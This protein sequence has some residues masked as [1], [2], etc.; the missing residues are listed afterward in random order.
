MDEDGKTTERSI[1][2][3]HSYLKAI[4]NEAERRHMAV[5][6]FDAE[7]V[8]LLQIGAPHTKITLEGFDPLATIKTW[9]VHIE[10]EQ[11]VPGT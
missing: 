3:V 4:L 5:Q 2:K 7:K 11:K 6:E 10:V 9:P 8:V 1:N